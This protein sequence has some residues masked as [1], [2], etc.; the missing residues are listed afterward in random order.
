MDFTQ[1]DA[2]KIQKPDFASGQV[3]VSA[4]SYKN[5]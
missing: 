4:R 5:F 3:I 1:L 2:A